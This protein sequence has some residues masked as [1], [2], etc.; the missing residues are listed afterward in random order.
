MQGTWELRF[1]IWCD[2]NNIIWEK[3]KKSF[4]YTYKN[5]NHLYFPDFYLKDIDKYI[6]IKGYA[7]E[8]DLAKWE[9]FP[10]KR[11]LSSY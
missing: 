4:T 2:K 3:N 9:Q 5:K 8:R 6:E 7:T 1:A 11:R 10:K